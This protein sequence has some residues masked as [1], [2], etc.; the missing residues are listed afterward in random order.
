MSKKLINIGKCNPNYKYFIFAIICCIIND[1]AFGSSNV[2]AFEYLKVLNNSNSF[3]IHKIFCYLFVIIISIIFY[4]IEK[5]LI[6]SRHATNI[7]V[8][9]TKEELPEEQRNSQTIELI[10]NEEDLTNYPDNKLLII[11]FLWILEEELLS[12][13]GNIMMHLDFWMLE[14]IIISFYMVLMFKMKLYKHQKLMFLL[15]IIPLILKIGTIIC[16]FKDEK[17]KYDK[18]IKNE[19]YKYSDPKVNK[20]KLLYVAI[21]TLVYIGLLIYFILITFRSYINTKLKWLIDKK[22]ISPIKL[23]IL[24]GII[25][26]FF[27]LIIC[28]VASFIPCGPDNGDDYTIY[29]YFCKVKYDK[30]KYLDNFKAFFTMSDNILIEILS[31]I[32]GVVSFFFNKYFYIRTIEHLTP[33]HVI[34]SFPIYYILNKSYLLIINNIKTGQ[35]YLKNME[36]AK[37]SLYFDFGSDVISIIG[38]LIFLEIIE[39]HCF[40][41][42]FNTRKNIL[43]RC[44]LDIDES[45]LSKSIKSNSDFGFEKR[46]ESASSGYVS[47]SGND[48]SS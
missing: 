32:L 26:F 28:I 42:D 13:Y 15:I 30:N 5:K 7:N 9:I 25:G 46:T 34:F 3:L 19:P 38:Y 27:S 41:Y 8:S 24:Y 35:P 39:F 43:E 1:I 16:S 2:N 14:L 18:N 40:G 48:N 11:V 37:I 31:I 4:Q 44:L 33:V 12:F 23:L 20:L 36:Y 29:D 21:P 10:H 6:K 47:N 45:E 17:N 22:Y